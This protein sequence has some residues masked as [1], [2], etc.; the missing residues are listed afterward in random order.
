[1]IFVAPIVEGHGDVYAV[2]ALLHRIA[3]A[4]RPEAALRVNN[5]IRVRASSFINDQVYFKKYITLASEKAAQEGG[6]VL[7]LIDCEDHCPAELGPRLLQEATNV[8]NDITFIIAL[9]YR[10]YES[11]FIYAAR[12]LRGQYGL[13]ADFSPPSGIESI[14]DAKG[15]LGKHMPLKYDPVVHQLEFTRIFDLEEARKSH[16]FNRMYNHIKAQLLR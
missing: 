11:W 4:V 16:S 2:P 3:G 1:M 7:V 5:P 13:P 14:R 6:F 15:W 8:R 9:A 12:S 10:E